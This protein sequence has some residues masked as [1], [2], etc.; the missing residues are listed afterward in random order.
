MVNLFFYI[1]IKFGKLK[2]KI[3]C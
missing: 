3:F 1:K 2:M